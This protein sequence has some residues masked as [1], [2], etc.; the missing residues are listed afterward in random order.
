MRR[1]EFIPLLGPAAAWPIT[2]GAQQRQ[3]PRIGLLLMNQ[4][5]SACA[6]GAY[7]TAGVLEAA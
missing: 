3:L 5:L 4:A 2:A 1:R 7:E 6:G